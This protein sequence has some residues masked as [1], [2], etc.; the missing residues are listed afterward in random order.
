[1]VE[2][3]SLDHLWD[4]Q[5]D[6]HNIEKV[7][8]CIGSRIDDV[9]ASTSPMIVYTWIAYWSTFRVIVVTTDHATCG[10]ISHVRLGHI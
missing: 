8:W 10:G 2:V 1:M 5:K 9:I 6:H 3:P 4:G 7:I